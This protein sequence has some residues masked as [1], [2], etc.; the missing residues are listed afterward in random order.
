MQKVKFIQWV[1]ILMLLAI[2]DGYAD[3]TPS[4]VFQKAEKLDESLQL[5]AQEM[6]IELISLPLIEVESVSPREVYFQAGTLHEK[7]ARLMFEF[8]GKEGKNIDMQKRNAQP[9]DV[10]S[11]LN[12]VEQHLLVVA[13]QMDLPISPIEPAPVPQAQPK[14]VFQLIVQ[15]NRFTNQLLDFKFSPAQSHQ[16]ITEAITLAS[17]ILQTYPGA[18]AVFYPVEKQRA[19]TPTDVYQ[20]LAVMYRELSGLFRQFDKDCLLLGESETSREKVLPSDVY[21][22]AVLFVSQFGYWHSMLPEAPTPKQSYYPGKVLPSD[23]YQR[24]SILE[25]QIA[26]LKRVNRLK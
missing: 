3:V 7:T 1:I 21:D 18:Q 19:K 2:P 20:K 13:T 26:E 4:Q 15:L 23:V 10:L 17:A 5:F 16:K 8:T 12:Q 24:L 11:L 9:K 22:L 14:N 6:G 25:Q